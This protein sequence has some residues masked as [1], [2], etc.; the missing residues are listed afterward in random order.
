MSHMTVKQVA[1][2]LAVSETTVYA[3]CASGEIR[4]R[5]IGLKRGTIRIEPADLE[6]YKARSVVV[7]LPTA[8][9]RR[10]ARPS[11]GLKLLRAA[12]YTRA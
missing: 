7:P 4:A 6:D 1:A 12:G 9:R 11:H 2:D 5:R 10:V 8:E 3:L